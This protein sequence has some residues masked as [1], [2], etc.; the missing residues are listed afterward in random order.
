MN[1][2]VLR[3]DGTDA[4]WWVK[5]LLALS[6]AYPARHTLVEDMPERRVAILSAATQISRGELELPSVPSQALPHPEGS[7]AGL[8]DFRTIEGAV[9]SL[10]ES[11]APDQLED[12]MSTSLIPTL[13]GL[14][15][16]H[17]P[18]AVLELASA[19]ESGD[20]D[21]HMA[22]WV[23]RWLGRLRHHVTHHVRRW[24]LERSL[25]SSVPMIRDGAALG[26]ASLGDPRSIPALRAAV[27]RESYPRL[28]RGIEKALEQ[29]QAVI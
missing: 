1:V 25:R 5:N 9:A 24:L 19:I 27:E 18:G 8:E 10:A 15:R 29:V 16:T 7:T 13:F 20:M 26:L 21:P 3:R 22:S 2:I 11:V 12:G 17:G 28:R 4:A 23:L 6:S 14:V